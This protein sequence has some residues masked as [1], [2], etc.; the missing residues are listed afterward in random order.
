MDSNSTIRFLVAT[1]NHLGAYEKNAIRKNDSFVTFEEIMQKAVEQK[2][3]FIVLGGDLFDENKPSHNTLH[4]TMQIFRKYCMGEKDVEIEVVSHGAETLSNGGFGV[5]NFQDPNLNVAIPVFA[6]HGNHDDPIG[7]GALSAL[8]LLSASGLINYFGKVKNTDKIQLNPI[9]IK[10]NQTKIALYGL[11]HV[12]E[13]RLHRCFIHKKVH[14]MRPEEDRDSWFNV[15][16]IHQ[17]R[18]VKS[19]GRKNGIK[20]EMLRGFLD[21]VIWGH[22]HEQL[23]SAVTAAGGGY[24]II[25]PGSSI[26]S[27]P[28]SEDVNSKKVALLEINSSSY[29]VTPLPLKSVRPVEFL[30][31]KLSDEPELSKTQED[32]TEYLTDKVEDLIFKS[33]EKLAGIPNEVLQRNKDIVYPII[34]MKVDFAPD[35]PVLNPVIFGSKFI[36]RVANPHHMLVIQKNTMK[37]NT[38]RTTEPEPVVEQ[39]ST[40]GVTMADKIASSIHSYIAKQGKKLSMLSENHLTE[41]I[42]S[43]IEKSETTAVNSFIETYTPRVQRSIWRD[44]KGKED[45]CPDELRRLAST[46]RDAV[47]GE[48]QTE[49]VTES[50]K[51]PKIEIPEVDDLP[52]DAPPVLAHLNEEPDVIMGSNEQVMLPL[53]GSQRG[54]KKAPKK[55][56]KKSAKPASKRAKRRIASS[57]DDQVKDE[58]D[59]PDVKRNKPEPKKPKSKQTR[60][61]KKE[62]VASPERLSPPLLGSPER[63]KP[64]GKSTASLVAMWGKK[65]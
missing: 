30:S 36:N 56:S 33:K 39:R 23:L 42:F 38:S 9:L 54:S 61:P 65:K 32:V 60:R 31:I 29:R 47:E 4:R 25:Q 5:A 12:R 22:E 1:D 45:I 6:I 64:G 62:E 27:A 21:L 28:N 48:W 2:V 14:F 41:A 43:F 51:S 8:D 26:M 52:P 11:G 15:M 13:E 24:D 40:E 44:V 53:P 20:E 37:Q 16:M 49:N 18:N 34:R 3:D 10:K 50:G 63:P 57:D 19:M 46:I 58:F 35:Y 17:N 7:E 59:S 55:P